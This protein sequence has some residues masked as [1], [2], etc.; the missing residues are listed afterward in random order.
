[1]SARDEKKKKTPQGSLARL[2]N[3]AE[4]FGPV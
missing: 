1:M 2:L 4:Q 3:R